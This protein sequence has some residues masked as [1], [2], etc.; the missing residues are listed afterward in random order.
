LTNSLLAIAAA[1]AL[2]A[3]VARW[4]GETL[5]FAAAA[6]FLLAPMTLAAQRDVWMDTFASG[7]LPLIGGALY[8]L[9]LIRGVSDRAG[10][11]LLVAVG[12]ALGGSVVVRLTNAV[13][14]LPFG[15]H[16]LSAVWRA[17]RPAARRARAGDPGQPEGRAWVRAALCFALGAALAL[18][19]LLL[20]NLAVFGR[21]FDTGYAYSPF[22]MSSAFGL[23]IG[24]PGVPA[25]AASL[26]T[27]IQI[28]GRNLWRILPH[29]LA[30]FPLL[31]LAI[32][33]WFAWRADPARPAP[34]L[35]RW[36][37]TL[38]IL[39]IALPY[40][41]FTWLDQLLSQDSA[42]VKSFAEVDRYFYPWIFPLSALAI[43]L[44]DRLPRPAAWGLIALYAIAS[45]WLYGKVLQ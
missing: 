1:A 19:V 20:Y 26:V 31:L 10:M 42:A 24:K 25:P 8:A 41:S 6:L 21:P 2:Y 32:P 18:G 22:R 11:L 14:L 44:L 30:G 38:W 43:G 34:I 7:V 15:L 29:W 13:L 37:S 36:L 35:P 33:G 40:L 9:Y 4:R 17:R 39:A 28:L 3:L 5:A 23:A 45:L 27:A 12:L 16:L